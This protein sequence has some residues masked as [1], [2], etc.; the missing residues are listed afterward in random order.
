[1]KKKL[2][3]LALFM[4]FFT[5]TGCTRQGTDETAGVP[6]AFEQGQIPVASRLES[7][8]SLEDLQTSHL[9]QDV[10]YYSVAEYTE[11]GT[12]SGSSVYRR[13]RQGEAAM[14]ADFSGQDII[15]IHFLVDEAANIYYLY[16]DAGDAYRVF[17]RKDDK[18]GNTVYCVEADSQEGVM[19]QEVLYANVRSWTGLRA[20]A[21]NEQGEVIFQDTAGRIQIF[22]QDGK[23]SGFIVPKEERAGKTGLV[24]AGEKGIYSYEVSDGKVSL[25]QVNAQRRK[26]SAPVEVKV[27]EERASVQAMSGYDRGI[28]LSTKDT[29]WAYDPVGEELTQILSWTDPN[30]NLSGDY[31]SHVSLL[32]EGGFFVVAADSNTGET[33]RILIE[34]KNAGDITA[35]TRVTIGVKKGG[36][37]EEVTDYV[38][39]FN[40]QSQEYEIEIKNYE[41]NSQEELY[42]DLLKGQGPDLIDLS[43]VDMNILANKGVLEDLNQYIDQSGQVEKEDLISGIVTGGTINGELVSLCP[44]F[45]IWALAIP[46]GWSEDHGWTPE[47]M[48]QMGYANPDSNMVASSNHLHFLSQYV[49][50]VAADGFID[51]EVGECSFDSERFIGILNG[52]KGLE[53]EAGRTESYTSKEGFFNKEYLMCNVSISSPEGYVDAAHALQ[54]F[55]ELAGYPEPEGK[56]HFLMLS[57]CAYGINSASPHKEGAWAFL[58]Y[59]LSEGFQNS[60]AG[61]GNSFPVRK[62]AFEKRLLET[63]EANHPQESE[64]KGIYQNTFTFELQDRYPEVTQQDLEMLRYIVENA[65]FYKNKVSG[66]GS[67]DY[68]NIILEEV[69]AFFQG[70]KTAEETAR[71]IQNRMSLYLKE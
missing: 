48:L 64:V 1:M 26:M 41:N 2:A 67:F 9:L 10:L 8:G 19:D 69:S 37:S 20:G 6:N 44:S 30:V 5:I 23:V 68:H 56:P 34:E 62:D 47:R 57:N 18:D 3:L 28:L 16:M 43:F 14:I 25:Y 49:L 17:L 33:K 52:I 4:L 21:V 15:L 53:L 60:H 58:E 40:E 46:E 50:P 32:E 59:L 38:A 42:K 39:A 51:W 65:Y 13:P 66:G 12:Y 7:D 61:M 45:Y 35:R 70:A 54:G 55:G 36:I 24:N 31:V 29:L 22:N 71:V 63:I 11:E 27:S